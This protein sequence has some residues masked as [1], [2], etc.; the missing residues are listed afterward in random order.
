MSAPLPEA[1]GQASARAL[2]KGT[3]ICHC[4]PRASNARSPQAAA[5]GAQCENH[6]R[7]QPAHGRPGGG[8]NNCRPLAAAANLPRWKSGASKGGQRASSAIVQVAG[9]PLALHLLA[10]ALGSTRNGGPFFNLRAP[11]VCVRIA[12][13][14]MRTRRSRRG[15]G[16]PA[17]G[18]AGERVAATRLRHV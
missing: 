12:A 2:S 9:V 4:L 10:A 3:L 18:R 16:K 1:Q 11:L 13:S 15:G 17:R 7:H 5:A 14:W 6:R 8:H